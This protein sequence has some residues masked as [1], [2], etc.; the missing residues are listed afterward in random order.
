MAR[1]FTLIFRLGLFG[2]APDVVLE[3][4]YC[5]LTERKSRGL[6][7]RHVSPFRAARSRSQTA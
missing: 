6:T 1:A 2:T 5:A 4:R 7:C 3:A